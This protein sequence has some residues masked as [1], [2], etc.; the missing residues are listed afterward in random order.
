[1]SQMITQCSSCQSNSVYVKS[2]E[3]SDCATLFSGEFDIPLL[4]KLPKDDLQFIFDFV[5][6]SGSLK[7]MAAQQKVSYPTLRNRLNTLIESLEAMDVQ[8]DSAKDDVLKL[9]ENGTLSVKE[10]ATMLVKL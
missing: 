2:I 10:A 9:V 1:M 5:K 8:R 3:C 7:E 6:C 4:L